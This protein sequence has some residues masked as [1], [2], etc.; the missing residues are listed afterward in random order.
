MIVGPG[1]Y[2]EMPNSAISMSRLADVRCCADRPLRKRG[3]IGTI[4]ISA[5][6]GFLRGEWVPDV[7]RRNWRDVSSIRIWQ[8]ELRRQKTGI[9]FL[10]IRLH[11]DVKPTAS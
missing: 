6:G 8:A 5:Y 7:F 1:E 2:C 10:R 3:E 11:G 9:N 4:K